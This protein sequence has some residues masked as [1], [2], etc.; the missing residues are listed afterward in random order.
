MLS[1]R[2]LARGSSCRRFKC[3]SSRPFAVLLSHNAAH[4]RRLS[5]QAL[6]ARPFKVEDE[7]V[8]KNAAVAD[9][10]AVSAASEVEIIRASLHNQLLADAIEDR[11][12][13]DAVDLHVDAAAQTVPFDLHFPPAD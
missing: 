3:E 6:A 11:I 1:S 5:V 2:L 8:R 10:K 12:D 9:A 7:Y 4:R 13:D